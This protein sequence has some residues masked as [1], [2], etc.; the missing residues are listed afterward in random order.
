VRYKRPELTGSKPG[1]LLKN[2]IPIKTDHWDVTCPG[3]LEA[4]TV[5]HCGNSMARD[6]VWSITMT[7]I[8]TCWT[9]NRA[10]WNKGVEGV[11]K[12][13]KNIEKKLPF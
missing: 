1:Y 3:L 5:A 7:D 12:Q 8:A 6:F 10:T 9:E 13:M 4:D 2:Q 11:V